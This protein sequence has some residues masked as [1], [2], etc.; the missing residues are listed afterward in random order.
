[1]IAQCKD[2]KSLGVLILAAGQG[3]RMVSSLPKVLHGIAGK[4]MLSYPLRVANALKPAAI[5]IVVG[6]ES[7][8][9]KAAVTGMAK[10]G[11]ISRRIE[12]IQ[13]KEALGSGN[14]VL[15]A[16][17]F[18]K[19][20]KTAVVLCGDS[21]LLTYESLYGLLSSHEA[22]KGQATLLTAKLANPKSYGRIVRGPL[23]E[24]LRIVEDS[25][26]SPKEL[27]INEV[28]SGAYC[29]EVAS[30]LMG[31]KEIGPKGPKREQFLTD[32]M[33][34]VR[35]KGGKINAFVSANPEEILGVN[36]RVQLAQAER[37]VNRRTLERLMLSGVTVCDP[38]ST[39]VDV[40]VEIGPDTVVQ[41]F[42]ILRGKTKIGRQC[43]VG[44]FCYL[45]DVQ[46]GDEC[47]VRLS[48]LVNCRVLEQCA[49]GPF[50]N[51]RPDSVL[52]PRAKVG[53]F[54]EIKASR[55][56]AGSKVPHLS[57]IGDSEIMEDVNIGAGTITCNYDGKTKHKTVIG[58]K[59][60][61]GSNVNLVAP[62][63]VGRGARIGAGS[64]ITED[65]PDGVLAIARARQV[66]KT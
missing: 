13:Q 9:V 35:A 47:E 21:P 37:V 58:S 2:G 23:G 5:G 63:K 39:H 28:N 42:T 11:G 1:M 14:A 46:V 27:A 30:L 12:F 61:I 52:G 7:G 44:P 65:V 24:V 17:P 60:F 45:Q 4:P 33:E 50:S 48:H 43:R 57:Y 54:S 6:H 62:V 34:L 66:N 22:Q 49:I 64:T 59:A 32:I 26:A 25:V 56:G 10:E 53:N 20:F 16:V 3:T 41:P 55:V 8:T 29:F 38:A 40:D 19:K 51:I 18:L 36:S 15:E 31:L